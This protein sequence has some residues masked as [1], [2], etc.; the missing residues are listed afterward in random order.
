M[1]K[2]ILSSRTRS[3]TSFPM[4]KPP[5]FLGIWFLKFTH[6]PS[7]RSGQVIREKVGIWFLKRVPLFVEKLNRIIESLYVAV[8]SAGRLKIYCQILSIVHFCNKKLHTGII[9]I[10]P[11]SNLSSS[12]SLLVTKIALCNPSS[13]IAFCNADISLCLVFI[14][15]S[16]SHT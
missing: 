8:A 16:D 4:L 15:A 1:D 2:L 9:S 3:R 14:F 13:S 10:I 6:F 11:C 5:P 12:W 7:T